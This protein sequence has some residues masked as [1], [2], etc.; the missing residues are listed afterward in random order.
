MRNNLHSTAA[1]DLAIEI[2]SRRYRDVVV[3]HRLPPRPASHHPRLHSLSQAPD[4][5][6]VAT[7]PEPPPTADRRLRRYVERELSD[8]RESLAGGRF[9]ALNYESLTPQLRRLAKRKL[10]VHSLTSTKFSDLG[11]VAASGHGAPSSFPRAR[12]IKKQERAAL[13]FTLT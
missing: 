1:A 3:L 8:H 13:P 6:F 10:E 5:C 9:R 11:F 7:N 4:G 12:S 2:V